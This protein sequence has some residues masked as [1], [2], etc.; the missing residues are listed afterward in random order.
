[1]HALISGGSGVIG[2]SL[3]PVLL[4]HGIT[5]TSMMRSNA[6]CTDKNLTYLN[7][8]INL[9]NSIDPNIFSKFDCFI[10]LAWED[11]RN[12]DSSK[13]LEFNLTAHKDFISKIIRV[14]VKNIFV[15]GSCYEYGLQQGE[16]SESADL[17]PVTN[18]GKSKKLLLEYLTELSNSKQCNLIWGRLFYIY[19]KGQPSNTFYG[20]LEKAISENAPAFE[21]Q[22]AD[23]SLDYLGLSN[24]VKIMCKLI[25]NFQNYQAVNICSGTPISL[26][27]LAQIISSDFDSKITIKTIS[28]KNRKHEPNKFWGDA[29]Y[30][31]SI[32]SAID[33]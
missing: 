33:E 16:L 19:G 21:I 22:S 13:H 25:I 1:M 26:Q 17:V 5:L 10:D 24:A 2:K 32:L 6:E 14:G 7:Q 11:V 3:I 28:K 20:Q 15:L 12:I 23:K 29:R 31:H 18:Y 4:D 8:S 27:D 30:L 9:N